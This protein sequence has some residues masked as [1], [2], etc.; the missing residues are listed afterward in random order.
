MFEQYQNPIILR[1]CVLA[2]AI[3][4]LA[5][6]GS[7]VGTSSTSDTSSTPPPAPVV[8]APAMPASLT[9][10]AANAQVNLSWTASSGATSYHVKRSTTSGG[11]FTQIA[12]PSAAS[13]ADSSLTNGTTYFYV[14]SALNSAG[15][16]A[17]S[18]QVSGVP[19]AAA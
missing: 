19:T 15:E 3:A 6:C 5:G 8:S 12:A 2:A 16:S 9:A 13:Y 7:A 10:T 18:A 17:N 4:L 1:G 14:V 11:P